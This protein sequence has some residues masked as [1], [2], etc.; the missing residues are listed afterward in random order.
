MNEAESY[1]T[2]QEAT[3]ARNLLDA[4]ENLDAELLKETIGDR[5]LL[6]IDAK[7]LK[8]VSGLVLPG[9]AAPGNVVDDYEEGA[10]C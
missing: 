2:G 6:Y 7:V 8:L 9:D 5:C 4:F 3:V 10:F 1:F